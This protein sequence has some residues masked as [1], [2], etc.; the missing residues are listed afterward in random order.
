LT[1]SVN[2]DVG[3]GHDTSIKVVSPTEGII[4]ER[5]MYF[6]YEGKPPV[7]EEQPAPAPPDQFNSD[8]YPTTTGMELKYFTQDPNNEVLY[9]YRYP[10]SFTLE[11][12]WDFSTGPTEGERSR[13]YVPVSSVP[14]SVYFPGATIARRQNDGVTNTVYFYTK[15][16]STY[17]IAGMSLQDTTMNDILIRN[18]Q[19]SDLI[20]KFP[21]KVG[22]SW[23]SQVNFYDSH[24]QNYSGTEVT[25]TRII[26]KN[27]IKVP[28]G[29]YQNCYMVQS[30]TQR[31]FSDGT[32]YNWI[33]YTW[34]VPGVGSVVY[35]SSAN[36]EIN[37]VFTQA[38][39][40]E[41]LKEVKQP[42]SG[43]WH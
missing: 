39:S 37:D 2:Q 36:G 32:S 26:S 13:T 9:N 7:P 34:L 42:G 23:V 12:P 28:Q 29:N 11:G 19:P 38:E 14:E 1:V 30:K 20:Y 21:F 8:D 18:Y 5:P 22:D 4:C 17:Y 40:I 16:A 10:V 24:Y 31:S 33:E 43:E 25:Y 6:S 41:R 3:A 35:V 27:S 15:D